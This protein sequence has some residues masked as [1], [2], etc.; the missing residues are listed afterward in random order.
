MRA[1]NLYELSVC[2]SSGDLAAIRVGM[3]NREVA[4]IAGAPTPYVSGLR[5]WTYYRDPHGGGEGE[6][7]HFTSA[8]YVSTV[9][10]LHDGI[11]TVNN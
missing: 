8:G 6:R 2:P 11:A 10:S 1:L 3:S 4:N 5:S 9:Y 7:V